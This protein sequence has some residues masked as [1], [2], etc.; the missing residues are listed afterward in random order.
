MPYDI[1]YMW[2][3]IYGTNEHIYRS[4]TMAQMNIPTDQ[5]QTHGHREQSCG[6][7]GGGGRRVMD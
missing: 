7:Q 4:E 3:L 1:T 5:K 2:N 6:C